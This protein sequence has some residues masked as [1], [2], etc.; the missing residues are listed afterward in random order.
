MMAY[1]IAHTYPFKRN[2]PY[3]CISKRVENERRKT[4]YILSDFFS[5]MFTEITLSIVFRGV[6]TCVCV[7]VSL[8]RCPLDPSEWNG[9]SLQGGG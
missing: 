8:K 6:C 1:D 5:Y 7:C 9:L 3:L 2:K 4:R